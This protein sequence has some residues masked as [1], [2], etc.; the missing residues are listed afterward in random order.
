M[1]CFEREAAALVHELARKE[2]LLSMHGTPYVAMSANFILEMDT[3]S[4]LSGIG[5]PEVSSQI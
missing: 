3:A 4:S 1:I 2:S 5:A